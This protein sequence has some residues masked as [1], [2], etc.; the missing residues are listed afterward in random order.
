VS[1]FFADGISK[2]PIHSPWLQAAASVFNTALCDTRRVCDASL[3][4]GLNMVWPP[5]GE[6][7]LVTNRFRNESGDLIAGP[8]S[9]KARRLC[10]SVLALSRD[11]VAAVERLSK[12]AIQSNQPL[13][14]LL[15]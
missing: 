11:P 15:R 4:A 13:Q 3:L 1:Q 8:R 9:A 6:P 7:A 5:Q 12:I 10:G 2:D 14:E